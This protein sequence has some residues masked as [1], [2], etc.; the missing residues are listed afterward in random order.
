MKTCSK[1]K[2]RQPERDYYKDSRKTD[3]L[4]SQCKACMLSSQKKYYVK[5]ADYIKV[6]VSEW[7]S[8][9]RDK[10]RKIGREWHQRNK[11]EANR[12]AK[13]RYYASID[14]SRAR[15]RSHAK[16]YRAKNSDI[17]NE[18]TRLWKK[19][20]SHLVYANAAKR[21]AN[22]IKAT[23]SWANHKYIAL[24]YLLAKKEA[25][26]TGRKVHVDHIIPLQGKEVCGL[27]C[28]DNMQL[29]FAEDNL[30]KSNSVAA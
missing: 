2:E 24:W 5:N 27:H 15:S 1:C 28:E 21:R 6:K 16:A 11:D 12:K 10:K 26:R 8:D 29:L 19:E 20:N 4:Q 14:E 3:G 7:V 23:P 30:R 22:R 13:I 25:D 18:R 17:L 9:N